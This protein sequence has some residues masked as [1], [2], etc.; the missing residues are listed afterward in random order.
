MNQ[1]TY[2]MP[3]GPSVRIVC[4]FNGLRV[5]VKDTTC[6]AGWR[7]V[8]MHDQDNLVEADQSARKSRATLIE[9]ENP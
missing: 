8:S 5:E 6:E 3:Y 1:L 4:A 9:G 2:P 7:V